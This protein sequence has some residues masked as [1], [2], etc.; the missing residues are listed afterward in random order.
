MAPLAR[1]VVSIR[2]CKSKSQQKRSTGVLANWMA[3]VVTVN[4]FPKAHQWPEAALGFFIH[5]GAAHSLLHR[6]RVTEETAAPPTSGLSGAPSSSPCLLPCSWSMLFG[7]QSSS[8]CT[9]PDHPIPLKPLFVC[10]CILFLFLTD[11]CKLAKDKI[12]RRQ[13]TRQGGSS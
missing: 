3:K 9:L 8:F 6:E 5:G 11:L 13:A 4:Q 2:A 7:T 1:L 12:G 10:F